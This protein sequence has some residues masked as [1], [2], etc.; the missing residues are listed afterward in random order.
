MS[1]TLS[2]LE[3]DKEVDGIVLTSAVPRVFSAGLDLNEILDAKVFLPSA[4][5]LY[6]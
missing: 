5:P 1:S 3:K 4:V 2:S 6:A